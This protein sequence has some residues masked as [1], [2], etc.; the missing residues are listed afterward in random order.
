MRAQKWYVNFR[1]RAVI[2]PAEV[3]S[4]RFLFL[5]DLDRIE[6]LKDKYRDEEIPLERRATMCEH[7]PFKYDEYDLLQCEAGYNHALLLNQNGQV[8]AFGEGLDG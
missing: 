3:T 8:F 7:N 6:E 5:E 1:N 2:E 4:D